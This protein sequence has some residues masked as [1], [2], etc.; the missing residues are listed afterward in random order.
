MA[1]GRPKFRPNPM[2][3]PPTSAATVPPVAIR[4]LP[5]DIRITRLL[6]RPARMGHSAIARGADLLGIFPQIAGGEFLAPRLPFLGAAF[7]FGRRQ[8][9]VERTLLGIERDAVAVAD[10][11]DRPADCG[12]R[13][14][15]ADTE[16]ARRSGEAS[17]SDQ[18]DFAAHALP[19]ERGRRRQHFAHAGAALRPLV[20]DHKHV[21]FPIFLI[22]YGVEARFFAVETT[23]RSGEM[24]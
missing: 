18:R 4:A 8:V 21:A 15:V 20:A 24:Q 5:L 14:D 1:P 19:V 17:V 11:A 22:F 3:R 13:T 23:R 6:G 9:G 16:P 2:H 7:E 12:F 10:E